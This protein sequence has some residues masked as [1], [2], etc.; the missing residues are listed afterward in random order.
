MKTTFLF[1]LALITS[2]IRI[3][4]QNGM[5]AKA[6]VQGKEILLIGTMHTVPKI[7]KRSYKP[8][9]RFAKK[10]NPQAIY[11]ESPM[12]NDSISWKYLK[13]GWSKGYQKFYKLSDSLQQSFQFDLLKFNAILKKTYSEISHKELDYMINCFGYKRDN[14]NYE[15]YSYIKKHGIYGAKSPTR[16]EDGDLTFKLALDLNIKKLYNMDDQRTNKEYHKAWK[17]CA[18]EGRHNGDNKINQTMNKKE[19]NTAIL[20]AIF[21][22]LGKHTN[23]RKSLIRLHK[24]ASFTYV[25]NTTKNCVLGQQYWNERNLRMSINIGEQVLAS[26]H[27]RN[28]VIV[29]ASHVIGLEKYLKKKYPSIK[30][31]LMNDYV[32]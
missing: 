10:Y 25:K 16:H 11:V 2:V 22:K 31:I 3:Q 13:K 1:A 17:G 18:R 15:L 26:T 30:I 32:F 28:M 20:P 23:K 14:G 9:L 5:K 7:V 27:K 8:M 21:R 4:Y 6:P 12:P 19:Y 29:G 24:L